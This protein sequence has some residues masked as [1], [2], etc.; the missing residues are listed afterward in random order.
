MLAWKPPRP[1]RML[2]LKSRLL[3]LA[4]RICHSGNPLYLSRLT[5][6]C[7]LTY[8]HTGKLT[9][10]NLFL[11]IAAPVT[12]CGTFSPAGPILTFPFQVRYLVSLRGCRIML[13]ALPSHLY[14]ILLEA[15]LSFSLT[16]APG[17]VYLWVPGPNSSWH[18]KSSPNT[19][20]M[21][22]GKDQRNVFGSCGQKQSPLNVLHGIYDYLTICNENLLP[23][24]IQMPLA[25]ALN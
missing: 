20:W 4:C 21:A 16:V 18:T 12:S 14:L 22:S 2:S 1:P 25:M 8:C 5:S 15:C 23:A 7:T 13:W 11:Q 9:F 19:C 17:L 3:G 10:L 24:Q 6:L